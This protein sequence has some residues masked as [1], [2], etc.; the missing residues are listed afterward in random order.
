MIKS[1]FNLVQ[2]LKGNIRVFCRIRP[3]LKEEK[4]CC[5]NGQND[6][7][8]VENKMEDKVKFFEFDRVFSPGINQV[9][10]FAIL[11]KYNK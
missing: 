9:F 11:N 10:S 7:I 5:V 3:L 8:R 4:E 6:Q 2:E 1:L